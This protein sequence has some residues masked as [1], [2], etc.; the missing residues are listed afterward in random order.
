MAQ[1]LTISPVTCTDGYRVKGSIY[2]V[3]MSFLL[4]TGAAVTLLREDKW[5]EISA[6]GER[7]LRPWSTQRLVGVD[8]SPLDIR[9]CVAVDFVVA[10]ESFTVEVVVIGSLTSEAILGL[11]FLREVGVTMDLKDK[12][13]IIADR[14][15]CLPL[16][17]T[18]P[19]P[20]Q[21]VILV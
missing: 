12:Q 5:K 10:D 1:S 14:G 17:D 2:G 11:K 18:G 3:P 16:D 7:R 15:C 8:G 21:L 4:D 6:G 9:G 20:L 13:L 19:A